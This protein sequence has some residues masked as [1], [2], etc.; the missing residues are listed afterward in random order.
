MNCQYAAIRVV[1]FH[2]SFAGEGSNKKT[3]SLG[4][5]T[6][7]SPSVQTHV[8]LCRC[9][10]RYFVDTYF[11]KE[12]ASRYL[13]LSPEHAVTGRTGR[14]LRLLRR[15]TSWPLGSYVVTN[16]K[17][18]RLFFGGRPVRRTRN[19]AKFTPRCNA[20]CPLFSRSKSSP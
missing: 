18:T 16:V 9:Y 11:S 15:Q 10:T 14:M 8:W 20:P 1:D 12:Q 17:P 19:R 3:C 5:N 4:W 7:L 2:A 6:M 13:R